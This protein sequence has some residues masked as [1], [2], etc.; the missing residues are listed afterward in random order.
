MFSTTRTSHPRQSL[1]RKLALAI[2]TIALLGGANIAP[3]KAWYDAYGYWHPERHTYWRS[4]ASRDYERHYWWC[5]RHP[6]ACG[7]YR[8]RPFYDRNGYY[9]R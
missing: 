5:E 2:A 1:I 8:Y 3:A 6:Y 9:R 4:Y 7:D